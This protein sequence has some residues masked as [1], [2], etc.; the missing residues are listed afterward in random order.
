MAKNWTQLSSQTIRT[1]LRKLLNIIS[2]EYYTA[3]KNIILNT[4]VQHIKGLQF[5]GKKKAEFKTV[6][7]L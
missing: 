5:N 6:N 7:T 4:M 3:I 1:W 2:K